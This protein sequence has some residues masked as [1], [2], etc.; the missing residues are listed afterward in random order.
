[1]SD[2]AVTIPADV[3]T[4]LAAAKRLARSLDQVRA[5]DYGFSYK[6]GKT[7]DR[8]CVRFHMNRKRRLSDLPRDQRLPDTIEGL[9]VDV[10][11]VGY[12]PHDGSARAARDVLQPG[13][14]IGSRK[15]GTT[16]TLGAIVLDL[17]TQQLCLMSNWHVLCGG[18]EAAPHDEISQPG[19]MDLGNG[20][21]VARLE[22]WLRPGEQFDVALARLDSDIH[23]IGQLFETNIQ[24]MG[25]KPPVLGMRLLKSG[26]ASGV[27]YA[28]VD[29]IGGS[30]LLDYTAYG[31][32]PR[33]MQGFRLVPDLE[34][35]VTAI[36]LPG[37]SG[38][39]WV[40]G[41]DSR[42]VGLH[43]AGEDD[44]SPLNDYALAHPIEDIF[45]SLNASFAPA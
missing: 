38:S 40:D 39:L 18:P 22:R 29:G 27:T 9:E 1:V 8:A 2:A 10:L 33:W 30:Y 12:T 32:A 35:P 44:A 5:I 36:S 13:I 17:N 16:G 25:A 6:D 23:I 4:A 41:S 11:G 24:P 3:R 15:L 28:K 37:D 20:R 7:T 42:A 43:F 45:A 34:A 14:S 31:D 26:I 21:T 19:P